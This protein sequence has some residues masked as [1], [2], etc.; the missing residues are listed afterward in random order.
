MKWAYRVRICGN[1]CRCLGAVSP[2]D[3]CRCELTDSPANE[4]E[5][6][7]PPQWVP[8]SEEKNAST[9]CEASHFA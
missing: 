4:K 3:G 2:L 6:T 8:T 9:L 5:L 1:S 7:S